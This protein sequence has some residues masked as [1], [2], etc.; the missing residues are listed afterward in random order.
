VGHYTQEGLLALGKA[1]WA[2]GLVELDLFGFS[3]GTG[4]V[5]ALAESPLTGLRSLK[6]GQGKLD[7]SAVFALLEAP[8]L[9]GLLKL[10]LSDNDIGEAAATALAE[11]PGVAGLMRLSVR[12]NKFPA[13]VGE[14]F[15]ERFG[16]RVVLK[17]PGD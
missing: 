17:W 3:G 12:K 2:P 1:S 10:D 9:G 11:A 13:A 16:D 5:K 8:W 15:R 6:L 7:D 14:R 4:G